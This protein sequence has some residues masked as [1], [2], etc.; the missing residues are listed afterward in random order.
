MRRSPRALRLLPRQVDGDI[1]ALLSV[2]R[3]GPQDRRVLALRMGSI[4]DRR[5][6]NA[7]DHAR[8]RGELVIHDGGYYRLAESG[9]E[10]LAWERRAVTSRM[11]TFGEQ[12]RAMRE[13]VARRWPEQLRLIS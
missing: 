12:L 1:A 6:R 4:E 7:I 11:G 13:T 5:V 8:R 9:E 2:L 10:Y 3:D